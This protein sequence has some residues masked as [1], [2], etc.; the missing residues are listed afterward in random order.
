MVILQRFKQKFPQCK[1]I[2]VEPEG[3]KGMSD[4]LILGKPILV[5]TKLFFIKRNLYKL[6]LFFVRLTH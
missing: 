6:K 4:S 5:F 2:G 1:I 3:A